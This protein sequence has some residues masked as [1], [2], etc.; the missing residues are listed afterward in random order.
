MSKRLVIDQKLCDKVYKLV[1]RKLTRKEIAE[2]LEIGHS[3]VCRIVDACYDAEE[4][5]RRTEQRSMTK[6]ALESIPD[7]RMRRI[8]ETDKMILN[9]IKSEDEQ[10]PGQMEMEMYPQDPDE[11]FD[12]NV[13]AV[14]EAMQKNSENFSEGMKAIE[15]MKNELKQEKAEAQ[16]ARNEMYNL[17]KIIKGATEEI[18]ER[19]G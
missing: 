2:M 17:L 13:K 1:M 9:Q 10:V 5:K 11:Q 8:E 19:I 15:K 7:E 14:L 18:M 16:K 12:E 3:T 4:Y 6:S